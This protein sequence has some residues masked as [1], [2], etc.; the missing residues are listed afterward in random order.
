MTYT[1]ITIEN[2]TDFPAGSVVEFNYGAMYGSERGVV[3][4]FETSRFGT[5]LTAV[6]DNGER[7]TISGFSNIGIGVYL[8][9]KAQPNVNKSSPWYMAA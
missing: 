7:K 4:G 5:Q 2:A 6:T 8:I 3:T 9:E 1:A